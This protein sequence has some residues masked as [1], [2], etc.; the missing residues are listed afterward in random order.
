MTF[1]RLIIFLLVC[2]LLACEKNNENS[3]PYDDLL[4]GSWFNPRYN[5]SIAI[6]DRTVGLLEDEYS[7][8]FNEDNT[9]V[10]RKNSGWCGTP[11]I[12][13]TSFEGTWATYDSLIEI[14][15]GFWGGTADYQWKIQALSE[16]TLIILRLDETYSYH[17]QE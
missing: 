4:I 9:F 12:S 6:Y 3:S 15:V 5:D 16:T 8:T 17:D 13:Y 10:E 11:P 1:S 7:F 14:S 2:S